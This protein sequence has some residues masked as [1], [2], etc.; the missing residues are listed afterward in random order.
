MNDIFIPDADVARA[1]TMDDA[2]N[3][4]HA[5]FTDLGRGSSQ[6]QERV[7]IFADNTSLSMMGAIYGAE[8][9]MGA[10]IYPTVAGQF[11]FVIP[12]FSTVTGKLV[13]IVQGNQLTRLRTAAVTRLVANISV[14]ASSVPVAIFGSG[15]QARAH[16]EAFCLGG[17]AS[18]ILVC[19]QVDGEDFVSDIRRRYGIASRTVEAKLPHLRHV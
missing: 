3:V 14:R 6:L 13:R 16:A 9:V 15:I 1:I 18:E 12:L 19:A 11:D 8:Q 17:F 7:R 2:V 10:K 5:A 4:M